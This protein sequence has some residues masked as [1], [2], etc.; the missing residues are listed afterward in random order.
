MSENNNV[1]L[2]VKVKP[3]EA[4][5]PQFATPKAQ[6][7]PITGAK[8]FEFIGDVKGELS[9]INWTSPEELKVYT[10]VVVAAT[11]FLGMSLYIVDLLIQATLNGLDMLIRWIA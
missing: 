10:K 2:A 5:K 8:V 3:V 4:K 7:A 1:N 11:F 9:K 6:E